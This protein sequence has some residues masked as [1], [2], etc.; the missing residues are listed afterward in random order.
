MR[1]F[2]TLILLSAPLIFLFNLL[3]KEK[4]SFSP[5]CPQFILLAN[6]RTQRQTFVD[7]F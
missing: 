7:E 5:I 6:T 3:S 4:V 2:L 1:L